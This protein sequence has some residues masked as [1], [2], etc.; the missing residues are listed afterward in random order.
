MTDMSKYHK[1]TVYIKP[2][3]HRKMQEIRAQDKYSK[4][5]LSEFFGKVVDELYQKLEERRERSN[6][7]D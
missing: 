6:G 3:R 2:D 4:L 5:S 1:K 7:G